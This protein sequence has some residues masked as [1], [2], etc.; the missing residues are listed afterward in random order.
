MS[1]DTSIFYDFH[2]LL[3]HNC[4]FN[5]IVGNRGAGKTY[6]SKKLVIKKFLKTGEQFVYL[7][8]YKTEID[9]VKQKFITDIQHEF[10]D[11]EF[12]VKGRNI[13]INGSLAGYLVPLST[14]LTKKS[15]S[16][17]DV[18]TIIFDE[19]VIDSKVIHYLSNEVEAFLEFF[20]TVARLRDNVRVLF[21][22]NAV[23]V[24]NPYFTY[25]K[26]KPKQQKRFTKYEDL[27]LVEFVQN[28]EFKQAKYKTRFGKLI[29]GTNYGN[30][31][32]ENEFLKDNLNFVDKKTGNSKYEF[33]VFYNGQTFGFWTDYKEGLVFMSNDYDP[34]N[35][36]QYAVTDSEHKINM[37]LVKSVNRSL[38]LKGVIKAYENGYLRFEDIVIKNQWL[39]IMGILKS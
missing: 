8:R 7:R 35:K 31:A 10:P 20:E 38:Y 33:S 6:G 17:H 34:S 12:E 4:L 30:Y 19:F 24:V 5:F 13:L 1:H 36:M 37:M 28:E 11:V 32:I 15:T 3:S 39:E 23:S 25:W 27:W 22:S 16:Y 21:L 2:A 26:I 29:K 9:D 18:T 14:A